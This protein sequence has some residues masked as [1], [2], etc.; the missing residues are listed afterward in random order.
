MKWLVLGALA[1][2]VA[3]AAL[4]L[5]GGGSGG[6]TA[7]FSDARGLVAGNDVRV[8]GAIAGRVE[9]VTL[10]RR[11]TA[12]VRFTVDSASARPRSD[13]VAGIRPVDLLGDNYLALSPGASRSPL[14]G[15]IPLTRTSN[16]PRLDELLSAFR[17]QTRTALQALLVEGGL[18]L[19]RRGDDLSRAAVELRP[20]LAAAQGLAH[21][22]NE[23]SDAVQRVITDASHA[24]SRLAARQDDVG[25]SI[26]GLAATVHATG[27]HATALSRSV[28]GMPALLASARGITDRLTATADAAQPLARS[29]A[30]TAT[31]LAEAVAGAPALIQRASA[32]AKSFGPAIE[33][34]RRLLVAADPTLRELTTAFPTLRRSAPAVD[35][36]MR[37]FDAAAPGISTGFF[38]DFPDQA[39]ESGK[40][41]F[42][43]FADP[44]RAYWRGAAVF[45]CEAFGVPVRPGCLNN[46]LRQQSLTK[47][48]ASAASPV[49]DYL[50]GK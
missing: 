26:D 41:P 1:A 29:L 47:K 13:A 49:L 40:Q 27:S 2:A 12:L 11:G 7:E 5:G 30:A 43:P 25:R 36:L 44:R 16:A 28:A 20:A 21:D 17:P 23:Q 4:Q 37:A 39:A 34:G 24:T 8:G 33:Q 18:A 31:P 15:S 9:S 35:K 46:V 14:R 19:D 32:T 42:D 45:S 38:L 50:L 6:Y 3:G 48:R 10:T 22:V